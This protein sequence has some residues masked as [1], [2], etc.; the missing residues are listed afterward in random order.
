M[1]EF[2]SPKKLCIYALPGCGKVYRTTKNLRIHLGWHYGV[3]PYVCT[4]CG[5]K[6]SHLEAL[7]RHT[8][9]MMHTEGKP[10][11]F[12]CQVCSKCFK[13]RCHLNFILKQAIFQTLELLIKRVVPDY[14]Q[15][16][17]RRGDA[18]GGEHLV[19]PARVH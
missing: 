15:G 9:Y 4:S 6:Y 13:Q 14:L 5:S 17:S 11:L 12:A 1:L 2:L 7:D 3:K 19:T 8:R 18:S 10:E 16:G